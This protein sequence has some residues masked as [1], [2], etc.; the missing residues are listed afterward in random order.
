MGTERSVD[1]SSDRNQHAYMKFIST[2]DLVVFKRMLFAL[3]LEKELDPFVVG[4]DILKALDTVNRV[5]TMKLVKEH[6]LET[7]CNL[8]DNFYTNTSLSVKVGSWI[9]RK[10]E[11]NC[12]VPLSDGLSA[13]RF[14]IPSEFCPER[15]N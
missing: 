12:G 14:F 2:A 1:E 13:Q 11:T 8:I 4:I 10:F 7:N 15:N 3:P 6:T 9:S 5:F